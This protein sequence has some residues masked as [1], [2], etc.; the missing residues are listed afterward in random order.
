ML[1]AAVE[2]LAFV[3]PLRK[4]YYKLMITLMS[5]AVPLFIGGVEITALAVRRLG[6]EGPVAHATLA[7]NESFNSLG[8]AIIG[9]RR[10][11]GGLLPDLSCNGHRRAAAGGLIKTMFRFLQEW[12]RS[13]GTQGGV[14]P[15][16]RHQRLRVS[17]R[18][19]TLALS[20]AT[21]QARA[22]TSFACGCARNRPSQ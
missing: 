19:Q 22:A 11:L 17:A 5:I 20:A 8:F 4:L 6:V 2:R 15:A 16:T 3:E 13:A 1:L 14:T 12:H 7:L 9:V 18:L 10:R 21:C